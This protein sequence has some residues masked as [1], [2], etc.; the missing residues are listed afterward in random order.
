LTIVG[1]RDRALIA[2]MAFTHLRTRRCGRRYARRRLLRPRQALVGRLHEKDGKRHE[3]PA[4]A[5][6]DAY[7]EAAKIV[8]AK[9]TLFF[10]GAGRSGDLTE[11][12]MHRIDVY[13]MIRRRTAA[14]GID[15]DMCCHTF[16]ATGLTN[17][18]A[19]GGTLENAQAMAI[20]PARGRRSSMTAPATRSR[21]M[22]SKEL[23]FKSRQ[24]AI[25][26]STS[27]RR[28]RRWPVFQIS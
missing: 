8:E 28:A 9:K 10:R 13:R 11:S 4:Q 27:K 1:L 26:S 7:L 16:R 3:M 14:A 24:S 19:N 6:L 5:Y 23:R 17:F 22:R 20:T 21:S 2:L 25:T 18:L 15:A 12:P